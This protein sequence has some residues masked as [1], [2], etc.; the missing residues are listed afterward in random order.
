MATKQV[1]TE[2]AA[3]AK[4]RALCAV[5]KELGIVADLKP[6]RALEVVAR[7]ENEKNWATLNA[8]QVAATQVQAADA[9]PAGYC[10]ACDNTRLIVDTQDVVW[11]CYQCRPSL[12]ARPT[13]RVP[14]SEVRTQPLLLGTKNLPLSE[15][16]ALWTAL[17]AVSQAESSEHR[18]EE[19]FLHFSPGDKRSDVEAWLEAACFSFS[20]HEAQEGMYYTQQERDVAPILRRLHGNRWRVELKVGNLFGERQGA[21]IHAYPSPEE[22]WAAVESYCSLASAAPGWYEAT[23]LGKVGSVSWTPDFYDVA[24]WAG[25]HYGKNLQMVTEAEKHLWTQKY[26]RSMDLDANV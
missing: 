11:P 1:I 26:K 16:A 17:Q 25:L 12:G 18:L 8:K 3:K 4:A 5:L 6:R 10:S 7:L 14:A 19:R 24:E 23:W 15:A 22:A 9:A 21:V 2:E 13:K 20:V